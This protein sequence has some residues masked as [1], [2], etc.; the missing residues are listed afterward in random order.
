MS[1]GSARRR[2][3]APAFGDKQQEQKE[4][5]WLNPAILDACAAAW[6]CVQAV[7]LVAAIIFGNIAVVKIVDALLDEL[8]Y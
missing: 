2:Y 3:G 7:S 5:R 8:H 1:I 4:R 6:T